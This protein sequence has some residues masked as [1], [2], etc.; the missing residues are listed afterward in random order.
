VCVCLS[1]SVHGRRIIRRE[2]SGVWGD[3]KLTDIREQ[4]VNQLLADIALERNSPVMANRVRSLASK[5]F[6]YALTRYYLSE[7]PVSGTKRVIEEHPREFAMT[8]AEL[9]KLWQL[10]DQ[11]D[12]RFAAAFRLLML[13]GQRVSHVSRMKWADVSIDSWSVNGSPSHRIFL[14][15]PALLVLRTLQKDS[16]RRI[17]VFGDKKG[18]PPGN[19]RRAATQLNDLMESERKWSPSDLRRTFEVRLRDLG[20]RPDVVAYLL[21]QRTLL[22]RLTSLSQD[23]DYF[24]ETQR[25]LVRWSRAIVTSKSEPPKPSGGKVIPL[26]GDQ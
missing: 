13:T 19:L 14:A 8:I 5:I 23:Y 20:I 3:R 15:P 18:F 11:L 16:G 10:F 1:L 26:F 2:L 12:K 25:A 17:Y 22:N 9:Q 6:N 24:P 21:N 7:N 4:D